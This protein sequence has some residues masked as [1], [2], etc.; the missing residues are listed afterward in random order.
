MLG[1]NVGV[2]VKLLI[3]SFGDGFLS[4]IACLVVS[5]VGSLFHQPA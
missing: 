3:K 1:I 4:L 5:R 2:L